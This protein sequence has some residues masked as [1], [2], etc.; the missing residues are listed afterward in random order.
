[1]K[2][3]THN[4]LY[5]VYSLVYTNLLYFLIIEEKRSIDLFASVRLFGKGLLP[6]INLDLRV[7]SV[8]E[9]IQNC[10]ECGQAG[11][12]CLLQYTE[13]CAVKFT[14]YRPSLP[15]AAC[16]LQI[17]VVKLNVS[18]LLENEFKRRKFV[19][20]G[21]YIFLIATHN[22]VYT[23]HFMN[24]VARSCTSRRVQ[25][26]SAMEPAH[27]VRCCLCHLIHLYLVCY[28]DKANF[29]LFQQRAF[30]VVLTKSLKHPFH[31]RSV[32]VNLAKPPGK[33]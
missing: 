28:V 22:S 29:Y 4:V 18:T 16:H 7:S 33:L 23:R 20:T 30:M 2:H 8:L 3:V 21:I 10:K 1:M 26:E 27:F 24:C 31:F 6:K 14:L 9:S 25:T 13:V 11:V 32:T 19:P 15:T 5:F 12:P 17:N